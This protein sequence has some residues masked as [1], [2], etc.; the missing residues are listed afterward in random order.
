[1]DEIYHIIHYILKSEM[2]SEE[3]KFIFKWNLILRKIQV[4]INAFISSVYISFPKERGNGSCLDDSVML[5]I[6]LLQCLLI[7]FAFLTFK[8]CTF[9]IQ[10]AFSFSLVFLLLYWR[11]KSYEL[12]MR[13]I[14]NFDGFSNMFT[15]FAYDKA[16]KT[17]HVFYIAIGKRFLYA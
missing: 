1:M 11:W 3:S 7:L 4:Q 15:F 12:I 13:T 9:F 8:L 5:C 2:K 16:A 14:Y 6:I 10:Y 17:I